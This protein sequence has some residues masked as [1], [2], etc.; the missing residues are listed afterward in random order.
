MTPNVALQGHIAGVVWIL[1]GFLTLA[2]SWR[3]HRWFVRR[4]IGRHNETDPVM[5]YL[6][7]KPNPVL[8]HWLS[9][10]NVIFAKVFVAAWLA[11]MIGAIFVFG[12]RTFFQMTT[13]N[14]PITRDGNKFAYRGIEYHVVLCRGGHMWPAFSSCIAHNPLRRW[15]QPVLQPRRGF[16]RRSRQ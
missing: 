12:Y 16:P 2:Y 8:Y 15:E 14:H 9:R 7:N 10:V 13:R 6:K 11:V 5:L 4:S 3:F 1:L